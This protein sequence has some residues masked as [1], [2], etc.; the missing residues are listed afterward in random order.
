MTPK[1]FSHALGE[2]GDKYVS[3]SINYTAAKKKNA[4]IKWGAMAACLCFVLVG[5]L[6]INNNIH[7][8]SEKTLV[9]IFEGE[10]IAIIDNNQC[11]VEV[12]VGDQNFLEG[13]TAYVVYEKIVCNSEIYIKD[14]IVGNTVVITYDSTQLLKENEK[15]VIS[16]E[17]IEL[18]NKKEFTE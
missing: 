13:A 11:I 6:T 5:A 14:L 3:E 4:W 15:N 16:I 10:I 9:S 2:I 1:K 7:H 8:K 17:N 12:T 18:T